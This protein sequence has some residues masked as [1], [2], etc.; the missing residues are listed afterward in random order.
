MRMHPKLFLRAE[1]LGIAALAITALYVL[2]APLWLVVVVALAPDL[3]MVGY[4]LNPK[5]GAGTYNLVHWYPVPL[6]VAGA[7]VLGGVEP[8]VW[9]GL[10]WVGHIGA[11]RALGYGLKHPDAFDH[12]HL[13]TDGQSP[14]RDTDLV[15]N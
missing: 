2:E 14:G 12:T 13:S 15:E 9:A 3:G 4:L 11:D 6:T 7:G 5:V 1:G 10:V 8:A